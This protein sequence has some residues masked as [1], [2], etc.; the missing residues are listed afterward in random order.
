M[1]G[2]DLETTG[3]NPRADRA[4]LISLSTAERGWL[5]D[6]FEVDP[7]PLLEVLSSKKLIMH[8]GKFDLGFMFAMGFGFDEDGGILDTMLLSQ[9]LEER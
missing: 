5:I 1:I 2:V 8:N 4:R 6:C 3:L 9:L 7:H